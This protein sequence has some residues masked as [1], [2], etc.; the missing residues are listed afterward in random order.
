MSNR[1]QVSFGADPANGYATVSFEDEQADTLVRAF[2]KD[3]MFNNQRFEGLDFVFEY[4][5]RN[6]AKAN[7]H[8]TIGNNGAPENALPEDPRQR[9][10][11]GY[12]KIVFNFDT[13]SHLEVFGPQG[14]RLNS[15]F[16]IPMDFMPDGKT[17]IVRASMI[18]MDRRKPCKEINP[19]RIEVLAGDD[20][21]LL[22]PAAFEAFKAQFKEFKT[23]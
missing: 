23:S 12:R 22:S 10:K 17:V 14:L 4:S 19:A 8:Y 13:T 21:Y 11:H 3:P 18:P 1:T 5:G 20:E 2:G 7:K 6:G 15:R 9:R 16:K